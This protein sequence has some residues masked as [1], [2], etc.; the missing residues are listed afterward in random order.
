LA[1]PKEVRTG[2]PSAAE[3]PERGAGER[4]KLCG[5]SNEL[6]ADS[7]LTDR[8]DAFSRRRFAPMMA[9]SDDEL[10]KANETRSE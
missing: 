8:S 2:R 7:Q 1:K 4:A 6:D 9:Q 3:Q 5:R 10:E